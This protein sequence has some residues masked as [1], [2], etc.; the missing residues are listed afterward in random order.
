[1]ELSKGLRK[2]S[3]LSREEYFKKNAE[4]AK[5]LWFKE[6]LPTIADIA[7]YMEKGD[8]PRTRQVFDYLGVEDEFHDM[9]NNKQR[10]Y[11]E[12]KSA[13]FIRKV[14]ASNNKD[15]AE[16]GY[17]YKLLMASTD[18]F[19]LE[20]ED[21]HSHGHKIKID[22]DFDEQKYN[23][24]VKSMFVEEAGEFIRGYFDELYDN[25]PEL[26]GLKEITVYSP[27]YCEYAKDHKVCPK[28]EGIIPDGLK[29]IGTFT[30]LGITEFA[31]QG[32]LSSM[33][34]GLSLNIN[35]IV[36]KGGPKSA[37]WEEIIEWIQGYLDHLSGGN[38]QS[39]FYDV[40]YLSRVRRDKDYED[41]EVYFV[42]SLKSSINHSGNLFGAFIFTS[43][44]DNLTKMLE[45]G[46]FDDNSTKLKIAVNGYGNKE[47]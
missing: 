28:C 19:I 9:V 2:Y 36:Q 23:F 43:S 29:N 41:E 27:L 15:I 44:T 16:A 6:E 17:F 14:M 40:A 45:A 21:C 13:K 4:I 25:Y 18:D 3:G 46:E 35:E 39:R 26:K 30:T 42:S 11:N 32:A 10:K 1:M 5:D 22:K 33:N 24:Y 20:Q 8:N 31:T 7:N 47:E 12:E 37:S 34:K 38:V